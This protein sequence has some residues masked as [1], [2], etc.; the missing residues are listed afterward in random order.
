MRIVPGH[1]FLRIRGHKGP[2]TGLTPG[3]WWEINR[4][5]LSPCP[6]LGFSGPSPGS[7][8]SHSVPAK[9][10]ILVALSTT[11]PLSSLTRPAQVNPP[12]AADLCHAGVILG[13]P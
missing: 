3:Q 4:D 11:P 7:H 12:S 13:R 8:P 1:T 5:S 9:R 6:A 2:K 10:S